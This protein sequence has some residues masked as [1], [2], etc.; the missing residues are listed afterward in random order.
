MKVEDSE[1]SA[2]LVLLLVLRVDDSTADGFS[3]VAAL[4]VLLVLVRK[5]TRFRP[6]DVSGEP[7]GEAPLLVVLML[8][9]VEVLSFCGLSS[10]KL[11][12]SKGRRY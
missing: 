9:A 1:Q 3:M 10:M 4:L 8:L 12:S 5:L 6:R 11:V 7:K 2:G